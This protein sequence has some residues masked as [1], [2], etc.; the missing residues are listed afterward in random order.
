MRGTFLASFTLVRSIRQIS[1]Q[2]MS[3]GRG[4]LIIYIYDTFP[5]L[6][7][8]DHKLYTREMDF[9]GCTLVSKLETLYFV[10]PG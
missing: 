10:L 4:H 6:R 7:I 5:T 2:Q 8:I 1:Q 9:A 3:S